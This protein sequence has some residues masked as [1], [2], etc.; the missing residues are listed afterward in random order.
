[1]YDLHHA[2]YRI[3]RSV[4]LD[5]ERR[6]RRPMATADL[7][8]H[9]LTFGPSPIHEMP[10]LARHLGGENAP[11]IFAKREDVNSGLAFG[12]NKTRK[13]EY[14][15]P[16][17]LESG[18]DTLVSIGGCQSTHTRQVAPGAALLGLKARLVQGRWVDWDDP[19]NDKVDNIDLSRIMVAD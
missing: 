2:I 7:P 3:S 9:S 1:V 18:A 11:R 15:V 12:G 17:S 5:D 8:R 4:T 13:L 16:D 10:R 6:E 14:I 19:V